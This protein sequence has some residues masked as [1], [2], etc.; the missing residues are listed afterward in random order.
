MEIYLSPEGSEL[1]IILLEMVGS[2]LPVLITGWWIFTVSI[3]LSAGIFH[4]FVI[5]W[6]CYQQCEN[7]HFLGA[8]GSFLLSFFFFLKT[9]AT[10]QIMW[11]SSF[12]HFILFCMNCKI[13]INTIDQYWRLKSKDV[14][15]VKGIV[16]FT[17][18]E[19]DRR[20]MSK[21]T[22]TIALIFAIFCTAS[23][24]II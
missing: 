9:F 18:E 7:Q 2:P 14:G 5:N 24:G 22:S 3:V 1:S 8:G 23:E 15:W 17:Y 21:S 11:K 13:L 12:N 20:K 16:I 19:M 10:I 6:D 4:G